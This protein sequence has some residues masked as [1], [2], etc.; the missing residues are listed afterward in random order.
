MELSH[1]TDYS[2][3]VLI[4]AAARSGEKITLVEISTTYR[5]SH[6]HLVKV[7][8]YLGKAG[9]LRNTRG[10]TGGIM[11]G[12]KPEDICIGDVIRSTESH[13]DLVECFNTKTNTCRLTPACRLKGALMEA[14]TAFLDV[15][16]SYTLAD[17]VQQKLSI[18]R[19]LQPQ[20]FSLAS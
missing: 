18:L 8:H 5:I 6:H 2:L 20:R 17:F 19:L 12:R 9:Y 1:F 4:L 11:L 10:R 7:V 3:R 15:L 16:D 14:R 13:L